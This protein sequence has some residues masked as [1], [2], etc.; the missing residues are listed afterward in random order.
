MAFTRAEVTYEKAGAKRLGLQLFGLALQSVQ[1]VS[2]FS[3]LPV[4]SVAVPANSLAR[5]VPTFLRWFAR[6]S[7][8]CHQPFL[9][10]NRRLSS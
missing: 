7:F 6:S 10:L 4:E 2:C 8:Y 3:S 5:L 1:W 9:A